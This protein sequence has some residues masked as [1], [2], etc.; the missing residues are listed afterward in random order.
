M[1]GVAAGGVVLHVGGEPG[2][3]EAGGG[4]VDG[5]GR[6]DLYAEAG[7]RFVDEAQ[8]CDQA[9]GVFYVSG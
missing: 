9:A 6:L 5:F 8:E 7:P 2:F 4:G 1:E 3:G